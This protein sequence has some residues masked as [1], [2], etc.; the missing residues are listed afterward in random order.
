MMRAS[1]AAAI[2]LLVVASSSDAAV[3]RHA[4]LSL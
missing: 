3:R 1:L 4:R 2:A